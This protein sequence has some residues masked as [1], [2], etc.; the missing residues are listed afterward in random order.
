TPSSTGGLYQPTNRSPYQ[1][2]G[3][4][5]TSGLGFGV[6]LH[7]NTLKLL[8][9]WRS[10]QL[11]FVTSMG[12][13]FHPDVPVEFIQDVFRVMNDTPRHT[14]QLLTKRPGRTWKLMDQL[15]WPTNLLFGTSVEDERVALRIDQLRASPAPLKCVSCEPLLGP[16]DHLNVANIVWVIV[17]GESGHEH[18][19]MQLQW[20]TSIRDQCV[21][22]RVPFYFEEWGGTTRGSVG[23]ELEGRLWNETLVMGSQ[24]ARGHLYAEPLPLSAELCA[25]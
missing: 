1:T 19:P 2:N 8:S 20:A 10:P 25:S 12:D 13:L 7:P 15:D 4:P 24:A 18:R 9:S 23:R 16:L 3:N 6:S 14:Y 11:I 22:A 5:D 21:A 17:A